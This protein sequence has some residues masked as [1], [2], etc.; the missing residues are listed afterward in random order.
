MAEKKETTLNLIR[1]DLARILEREPN[2]IDYFKV[3]FMPKGTTFP[4]VFWLRIVHGLKKKFKPLALLPYAFLRH[5]EYKYD[6]HANSNIHIGKG[7]LI[8][9][10]GALYLNCKEIGENFT[11]YQGVTLGSKRHEKKYA[12]EIPSVGNNVS[13]YTGAVVCGDIMIGDNAVIGAHAY[14]SKNLKEG[15]KVIGNASIVV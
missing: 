11:V 1:S 12:D 14:V 10:G 15:T 8:V 6:I 7:L 4:Y 13:I 2:V 5:Y 3:Y 9:H